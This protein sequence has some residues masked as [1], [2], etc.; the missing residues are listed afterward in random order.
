MK[1]ADM[2]CDTIAE[3]YYAQSRGEDVGIRRNQFHVDLKKMAKGDYGIQNFALFTSIAREERPFEYTMNLLDVFYQEMEKNQD[4]IGVVRSY[5]D[6]EENWK[7]GRMSA[8]LTI[9]EGAVCQGNLSFLRDFYR[10]GVRMMTLLWNHPN[11][12]GYPSCRDTRGAGSIGIPDTERGLTETG[13]AFLEE[14]ERLGMIID[15]SHLND[16]GVWDV[17]KYTKKP[18]VASHSNARALTDGCLRNLTDDMIRQMGERG[19]VLGINYYPPFL[20]VP[21]AGKEEEKMKSRVSDMVRHMKHIRQTG[22]IGCI[23]LGSDFDGIG[24][25]L[26]MKSCADLPL[27]EAEMRRQGFSESEIEAVFHGNVL[28][29]YREVLL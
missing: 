6:I 28:R 9:E 24:G 15:I 1:V 25:D 7:K 16:A 29:V 5:Q 11:E 21:E 2:H 12:L 14:M 4:L 23:G 22:G 17:F 10:L 3:I 26:E 19:C 20:K 8:L 18:F 13:I 27:L